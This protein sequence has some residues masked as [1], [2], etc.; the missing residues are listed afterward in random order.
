[1]PP[2]SKTAR[3]S[4]EIALWA[5]GLLLLVLPFSTA[6]AL[7]FSAVATFF[8]IFGLRQTLI[9]Q[10]IR[11]PVVLLAL[12]LFAWLMC[13]MLWS[14]APIDELLEGAWKYRKLAF[15]FLVVASLIACQKPPQFL[16]NFFLVGCGVVA[17]ASLSSRFGVLDVILGPPS[18]A[19]GGWPI[20]GTSEK[21][22]LHIGGPDNPTFGRNHITQGAF[23]VFAAMFVVGRAWHAS[24]N[25]HRFMYGGIVSALLACFYLI[26]VFSIQGR[27]GYLLAFLGGLFWIVLSL[28]RMQGSS[29]LIWV[30]AVVGCLLA[31]VLSSPHFFKR[32]SQAVDDV[33]RYSQT[34]ERTSQGERL[35]YWR[36]GIKL[37]IQ[38]PFYGYG[39]GAYAQAYSELSDEP[40]NLRY[41]RSQPHSEWVILLVQGGLVAF[42]LF[43]FFASSI[44]KALAWTVGRHNGDRYANGLLCVTCLFFFYAALNSAIWDLAEGH[45][46]VIF[47]AAVLASQR[48]E[49]SGQDPQ[50]FR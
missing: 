2:L 24:T 21:F 44:L 38:R 45:F 15:V 13:S 33:V 25:G 6:L 41:N 20:G 7:L 34:G 4:H 32:S 19:T 22:W 31:L 29:R 49:P 27:S 17:V 50:S 16:I 40:V 11:S 36:A 37:A 30:G 26:P 46:I 3:R 12:A 43:G 48:P 18:P 5:W 35:G 23:L 10:T 42:L 9:A 39:V 14:V 47:A 28:M 8:S 1:M